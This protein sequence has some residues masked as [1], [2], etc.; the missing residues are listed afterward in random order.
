MRLPMLSI[1]LVATALAAEMAPAA[2]QSPTSY[3][4]CARIPKT[5]GDAT[6]CYFA[7]YRQ[8]MTTLSGTAATVTTAPVIT[9]LPPRPVHAFSGSARRRASRALP[10]HDHPPATDEET[11]S[12]ARSLAREKLLV[13]HEQLAPWLSPP[14]GRLPALRSLAA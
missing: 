3:P 10:M 11:F 4:W 14:D 5:D 13:Q 9:R 6:A 2:V 1:A 8:C 7:S 12:P